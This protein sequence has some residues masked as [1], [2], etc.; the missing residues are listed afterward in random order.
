MLLYL[1]SGVVNLRSTLSEVLF[2]VRKRFLGLVE[3]G[4]DHQTFIT[5]KV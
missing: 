1:N 5:E 3:K 2:W 4:R